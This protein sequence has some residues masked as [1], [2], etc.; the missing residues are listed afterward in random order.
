MDGSFP[1]Q[2]F[3]EITYKENASNSTILR[4]ISYVSE[5]QRVTFCR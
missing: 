2:E 3:P 5:W 4:L 1:F